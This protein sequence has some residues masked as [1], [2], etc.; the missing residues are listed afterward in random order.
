[1]VTADTL[2]Q[3]AWY[4]LEQAGRLCDAAAVLA[5]EGHPITGAAVAMFGREELGRSRI[6]RELADR[7]DTG[8]TLECADVHEACD[9][10]VSKQSAGAFSTTVR[11]EP[12]GGVDAPLRGMLSAEPGS[13]EW[14]AA[15]EM[16]DLATNAKR[17]RNPQRRHLIRTGA[18]YVDLNESG[19]GWLR[20]STRDSSETLDEIVDGVNDYAAE[21]DR[22]RD[23]VL[24][25]DYPE[26]ARARLSMPTQITLPEPRWPKNIN[27]RAG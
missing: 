6:L 3:G 1:M 7:V 5:D 8:V 23:D 18:L 19:S 14:K 25:D 15:K 16:A 10:H 9:N 12:P 27:V 21:L 2:R 4:A 22:L 26:M 24:K 13:D 20:P 11:A 17:K